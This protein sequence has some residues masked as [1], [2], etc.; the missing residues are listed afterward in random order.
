MKRLFIWAVALVSIFAVQRSEAT[1]QETRCI[2]A[3]YKA[4]GKYSQC[5]ARAVS[6]D[7]VGVSDIRYLVADC[8]TRYGEM[9]PKFQTRFPTSS[10]AAARWVANGDG[11]ATDNLTGLVWEQK[12]NDA[13]VH[14]VSLG[15]TWSASGT[16]ADGDAY[17]AFLAPLNTPPCFAG[18]CDWRLPTLAELQTTL[19]VPFPCAGCVD[20]VLAPRAAST[21]YWTSTT[22]VPNSAQVWGVSMTDGAVTGLFKTASMAIR[23]VRGGL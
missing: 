18:Q 17:T 22:R 7:Y 8:V 16:A 11:T 6:R 3:R 9:W 19:V 13:S 5:L 23:A 10:C 15:A 2:H 12:T 20:A 21:N 14:G 4:A 1:A